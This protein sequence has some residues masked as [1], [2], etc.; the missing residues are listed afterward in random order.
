MSSASFALETGARNRLAPRPVSRRYELHAIGL[1]GTHVILFSELEWECQASWDRSRICAF[2]GENGSTDD[3]F[4]PTSWPRP[5]AWPC[6]ANPSRADALGPTLDG[7][8]CRRWAQCR[9]SATPSMNRSKAEPESNRDWFGK[10]PLCRM[11]CLIP[12]QELNIISASPRSICDSKASSA[13]F[14]RAP[15]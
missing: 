14:H 7:Y 4:L 10:T 9:K 8:T 13:N 3:L 1:A 15:D 12:E 2:T 6:P 5:A 11:P